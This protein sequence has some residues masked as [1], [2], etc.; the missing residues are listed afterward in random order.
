M[1]T[2]ACRY[3]RSN[4]CERLKSIFLAHYHDPESRV[5]AHVR[6]RSGIWLLREAIPAHSTV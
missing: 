6:E 4:E 2:R 1:F 3:F 5:Q